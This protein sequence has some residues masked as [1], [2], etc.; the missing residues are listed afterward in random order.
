MG[1]KLQL[2]VSFYVMVVNTKA[3]YLDKPSGQDVQCK[4]SQEFD[5]TECNRLFNSPVTLIICNKGYIPSG[6]ILYELFSNGYT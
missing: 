3:P 5:P 1:N 2:K 4:P 6:N